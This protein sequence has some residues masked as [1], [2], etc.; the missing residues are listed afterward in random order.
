MLTILEQKDDARFSSKNSTTIDRWLLKSYQMMSVEQKKIFLKMARCADVSVPVI[1]VV[2]NEKRYISSYFKS[3][4]VFFSEH[5][6]RQDVVAKAWLLS[7]RRISAKDLRTWIHFL[8][9]SAIG[10][11]GKAIRREVLWE[12][13]CW[14]LELTRQRE[15]VFSADFC[16]ELWGRF[17]TKHDQKLALRIERIRQVPVSDLIFDEFVE[18]GFSRGIK[19]LSKHPNFQEYFGKRLGDPHRIRRND[20]LRLSCN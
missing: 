4:S 11:E 12:N 6:Q 18:P 20:P 3:P 1:W 17:A 5:I 7:Y 16:E 9:S 8:L 10:N 13:L 2:P 15:D 14:L 19:V